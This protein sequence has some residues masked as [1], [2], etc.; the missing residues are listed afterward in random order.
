[1][2]KAQ[3][4]ENTRQSIL[5][6]LIFSPEQS[7]IIKNALPLEAW[8]N[9]A[10][11]RSFIPM[12]YQ[13][14]D[15]YQKAPEK[16]VYDLLEDLHIGKEIKENLWDIIT[17]AEI[18]YREGIAADYVFD[19]IEK[20]HR[21][22]TYEEMF[23]HALP[24]LQ[25]G[26]LD[27][28]DNLIVE[29]QKRR[30][31]VFDEPAT[32]DQL[33]QRMIDTDPRA[34]DLDRIKLDIPALDDRKLC[35]TRGRLFVWMAPTG[36]GKSWAMMY[37]GKQAVLQDR[38]VLH[39]SLE[40]S[41]WECLLRYAQVFYSY[42]TLA[43]PPKPRIVIR[44]SGEYDYAPPT[45]R[46]LL[47]VDNKDELNVLLQKLV[48]DPRIVKNLKVWDFP[49]GQLK[50]STLKAYIDALELQSGWAPDLVIIDYADIMY[51]K[52]KY[53]QWMEQDANYMALKGYATERNLMIV[54]ATQGNRSSESEETTKLG[55]GNV[56][57]S[58]N[59]LSH[60]DY[61]V[62]IFQKELEQEYGLARLNVNKSRTSGGGFEVVVT[63]NFDIGQ[64][65]LDAQEMT[66]EQ[67]TKYK[68]LVNALRTD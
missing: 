38:K 48:D 40:M 45:S 31:T 63:Q 27:E 62:S 60:V 51:F 50:L 9:D 52:H 43:V 34:D 36:F 68:A 14:I 15:T 41:R 67:K 18:R 12:I 23:A 56:A 2:P 32:L 5:G 37:T 47:T 3:L 39:V 1:M 58:Y 20:F 30:L 21:E 54:T 57:G 10:G 65:A 55:R 59:K 46:P 17:A 22:A 13:Y 33:V 6:L 4:P 25:K 7:K 24:M 29:T 28:L 44:P 53:E 49:N 11:F 35:P 8:Q 19:R 66:K 16:Q 61:L 64:F 42:R 26:A